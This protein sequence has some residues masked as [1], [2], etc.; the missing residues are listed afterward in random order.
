MRQHKANRQAAELMNVSWASA[1][2]SES[3]FGILERRKSNYESATTP[4]NNI[5]R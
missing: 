1:G 4:C 5:D 3:L 2:N